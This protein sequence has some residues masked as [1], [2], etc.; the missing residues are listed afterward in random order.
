MKALRIVLSPPLL[1]CAAVLLLRDGFAAGHTAMALFCLGVLPSLSYLVW[2]VTP[3]LYSGGRPTQRKLAVAFSVA[4]YLIGL[5]F[6]LICEGSDTERFLY[7]SYVFSAVM[8][9]LTSHFG[10][11]SS[12]HAAGVM[13]A[14]MLL[15]FRASPWYLLGVLLLLPVW[16]SSRRL[17]RHTDRELLLGA[18][19]P[20][21][22]S[23][24][25]A[26]LIA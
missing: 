14:V 18:L 8:I 20:T 1:I 4:G 22:V 3:P 15:T 5:I 25:L 19:Y 9:A 12:G 24:F 10:V 7:I 6:C 13:G 2:R 26:C 11:K 17:G 23:V 21:A 16:I